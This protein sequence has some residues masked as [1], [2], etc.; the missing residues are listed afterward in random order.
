MQFTMMQPVW[1]MLGVVAGAGFIAWGRSYGRAERKFL[2]NSLVIAALIYVG[3]AVFSEHQAWILH[4]LIGVAAFASFAWLA[5]RGSPLWLAVGWGLHPLWDAG[6][7]LHGVGAEVAP[8]WYV[9]AC[10]SFDW[11]VAVYIVQ[12]RSAWQLKNA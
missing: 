7:H 2:G 4:E 8:E 6:L 9:L 10:I 12:R 1:L 11:L 5:V 3:F